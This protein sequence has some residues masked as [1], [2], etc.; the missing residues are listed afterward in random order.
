MTRATQRRG[1]SRRRPSTALAQRYYRRFTPIERVLHALLMLTFVGCA[2]SGLP[3]IFADQAVGGARSR[4]SSAASRAPGLHPPHLR[5]R[6]DRRV[7]D[8][9]WR[10]CSTRA[11]LASATCSP[12]CGGPTRWCRSRRTSSTSIS[13]FKWFIGRGP[14]PQFDRWTYWE[15]FD[16]WAVFWGMFII[17]GSGSLLWFPVFFAR[18][19]SRLDVQH[20]R[21]RARRGGAARGRL[22]LHLPLLQ[23]SPA[24]ARSSRWTPWSSPAASPSTSSRRSAPSEYA[25]LIAKAGSWT[26]AK[27]RRRRTRRG[28]S[29][30]WWAATALTLGI[31]AIVLIVYSVC[32]NLHAASRAPCAYRHCMQERTRNLRPHRCRQTWERE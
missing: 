19:A 8:A 18:R 26:Q 15:K 6:D 27:R 32:S 1:R 21:A 24:A 14:Q 13:N 3:L 16:Y 20:R 17:G 7:R 29:A 25:R 9:T 22:H 30:G 5:G 10:W 28:G 11:T 12:C 23:R 31:V 2:L 4:A